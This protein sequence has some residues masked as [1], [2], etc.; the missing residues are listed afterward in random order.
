[1]V[2]GA[3]FVTAVR[4][5]RCADG[6]SRRYFNR[7][8]NLG[9]DLRLW[10]DGVRLLADTMSHALLVLLVPLALAALLALGLAAAWAL[11][12]AERAL[13]AAASRA[14]FVG[15][16]ALAAVVSLA[17]GLTPAVPRRRHACRARRVRRGRRPRHAPRG[18]VR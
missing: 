11:R 1:V 17:T 5:F 4:L 18:R 8:I 14:I 2:L 15:A 9:L 13:A 6:G 10:M 12:V 7:P 16:V 3:A